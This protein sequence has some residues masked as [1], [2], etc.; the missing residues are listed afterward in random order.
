MTRYFEPKCDQPGHE[1]EYSINFDAYF[2]KKCN[3]WLES[4][5]MSPDCSYCI[6]RPK[7]PNPSIWEINSVKKYIIFISV[8]LFLLAYFLFSCTYSINMVHTEGSASDVVDEEQTA[9]PDISPT[10]SIPASVL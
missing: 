6:R 5:C 4:N 1:S 3:I 7:R 8:C 10:L 9:T 2:C